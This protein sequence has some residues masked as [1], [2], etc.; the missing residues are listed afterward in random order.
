M[1]PRELLSIS[2]RAPER[3]GSTG[4]RATCARAP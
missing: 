1:V 3:Q 4:R 2:Y